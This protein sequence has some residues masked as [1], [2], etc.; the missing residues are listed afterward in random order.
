MRLWDGAFN[1]F[2][3]CAVFLVEMGWGWFN[4]KSRK[5]GTC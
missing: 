4:Y 1:F 2:G 3:G 5:D